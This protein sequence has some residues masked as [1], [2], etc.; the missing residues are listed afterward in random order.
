MAQPVGMAQMITEPTAELEWITPELAEQWLRDNGINRQLIPALATRY[1]GDIQSG[2]WHLTGHTVQFA[3]TGRLLDGQHRLAAIVQSGVAVRN[4]VVRGLAESAQQYMD[5]GKARTA[6]DALALNGYAHTHVLAAAAR[7]GVLVDSD[8]LFR[9][10]ASQRVSHARI[11]QW[12]ESNPDIVEAVRFVHGSP[13]RHTHLRPSVMAYAYW[14]FCKVDPDDAADF[15][16]RL[17]SGANLAPG[18]PLLALQSRVNQFA[19]TGHRP[20]TRQLLGLLYR[21]WNAYRKGRSIQKL[22]LV[23]KANAHCLPDLV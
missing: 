13:Q 12:V 3:H 2:D 14:R 22:P 20:T 6:G 5:Q 21:V 9:D 19:I 15:F 16:V 7:L 1:A 23:T 18:S 8:A 10:K 17:G 4:F 11:I